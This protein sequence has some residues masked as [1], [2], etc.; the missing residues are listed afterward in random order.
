MK[1]T[2]INP[3]VKVI[4]VLTTELLEFSK[5]DANTL[6][7]GN[8]GNFDPDNHTQLSREGGLIWELEEINDEN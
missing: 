2:Y 6:R 8:Q 3:E 1:K 5:P 4:K 7:G